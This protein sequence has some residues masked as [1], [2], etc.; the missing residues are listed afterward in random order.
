MRQ[1]K[2]RG[3]DVNDEDEM[4]EDA[5]DV[6]ADLAEHRLCESMLGAAM[7]RVD[8]AQ[9]LI[10]C[11]FGE[12]DLAH[13]THKAIWRCLLTLHAR[14][15]VADHRLVEAT[16]I[17]E[18]VDAGEAVEF[19]AAC[20]R[21]GDEPESPRLAAYVDNVK[22][23]VARR[24]IVRLA[25]AMITK[26]ARPGSTA[27]EISTT[28]T[29]EL[30][31][32]MRGAAVMR[33]VSGPDL[34]RL[35]MAPLMRNEGD[36]LAYVPIG[37]PAIDDTVGG[38]PRG[39]ILV[40]AAQKKTGKT[41]LAKHIDL[42]CAQRGER[43]LHVSLEAKVTEITPG[44]A[45]ILA[46]VKLPFNARTMSSRDRSTYTQAAGHL[47]L[48]PIFVEKLT[49]PTAEELTSLIYAH[50]RANAITVVVIDFAQNID[51]STNF[52]LDEQN[53]AHVARVVAGCADNC[54]RTAF[55]VFSQSK[56]DDEDPKFAGRKEK[57]DPVPQTQ[58]WSRLAYIVADMM[59]NVGAEDPNLRDLTRF[60]IRFNRPNG[61][62][63]TGFYR[64]S[65]ETGRM[66]VVGEDGEPIK[67]TADV[68]VD[69]EFLHGGDDA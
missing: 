65:D 12:G 9:T 57:S 43:V 16:L 27:A 35:A 19:I 18:G 37:V 5:A 3:D 46:S 30:D 1:E 66:S 33:A 2:D 44:L 60:R 40:V 55:V 53:H 48:L 11:G 50:V 41:T 68:D 4:I 24:R 10:A 17:D 23:R 69:D 6:V 20:M 58:E 51:R 62:L 34:E 15:K 45:E 56:S 67:P 25:R 7:R 49:Y 63:A 13:E 61:K 21:D 32:I 29:T 52:K 8:L 14:G 26:A 31:A 22:Q 28:A 39:G 64:Y 38:V 54:P 36:T 59:R 47:A 42:H